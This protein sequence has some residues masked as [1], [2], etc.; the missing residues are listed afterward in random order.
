[1]T[2]LVSSSAECNCRNPPIGSG[3]PKTPCFDK[4]DIHTTQLSVGDL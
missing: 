3:R 2:H 4:S 1:M